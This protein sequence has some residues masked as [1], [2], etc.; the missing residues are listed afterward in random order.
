[1]HNLEDLQ[2]RFNW[3]YMQSRDRV[4]WLQKSFSGEVKV[5]KNQKYLVTEAGFSI[6]DRLH[7]LEEKDK[8]SLSSAKKQV[9]VE[10]EDNHPESS[11]EKD[12][13]RDK[14]KS[15]SI[16]SP[17]N[18][19]ENGRQIDE[20]YVEQLERENEFLK[21]ELEQKNRQIQQLLPAAQEEEEAEKGSEFKELSLLQVV[22]KWFTTK[23]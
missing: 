15:K 12:N 22:K 10:M 4:K 9:K 3:S 6:L 21:N 7:Q 19:P 14:T 20:K 23:T 17:L 13:I 1:M 16:Q 8:L 18:H 2:D 11:A 5:G